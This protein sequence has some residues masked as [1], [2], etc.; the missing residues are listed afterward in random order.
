VA[1]RRSKW[2]SINDTIQA[3]KFYMQN[4]LSL[5]EAFPG[6]AVA[7]HLLN[8]NTFTEMFM[9]MGKPFLNKELVSKVRKEI[10]SYVRKEFASKISK[11][12][13]SKVR[14]ELVSKVRKEIASE[15]RM[16]VV[17]KLRKEMASKVR[18]CYAQAQTE[19]RV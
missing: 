10:V 19:N 14:M 8:A 18:K 1:R 15:V 11:E 17:S 12:I 9:N 16:E 3:T 4:K 13:A 2:C 7:T 6:I 5:Q